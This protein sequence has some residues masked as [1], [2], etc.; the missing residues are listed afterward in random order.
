[1]IL[2]FFFALGL[3]MA[4]ASYIALAMAMA[5]ASTFINWIMSVR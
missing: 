5:Q 4:N 1:M 3:D 2:Q